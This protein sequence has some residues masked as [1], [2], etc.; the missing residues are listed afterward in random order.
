MSPSHAP[1]DRAT[2]VR[3]LEHDLDAAA[4]GG[5]VLRIVRALPG[6]G[7]TTVLDRLSSAFA[8]RSPQGL[9]LRATGVA[10]ESGRQNGILGQ[11]LHDPSSASLLDPFDAAAA[12]VVT[13]PSETTSLVLIDDAHF[14]DAASL[15]ALAT[16]VRHHPER[17]FVIVLSA[18]TDEAQDGD[19]GPLAGLGASTITLGPM[20]SSEVGRAA[21]AAG[22]PLSAPQAEHLTRHSGGIPRHVSWLL[23]AVPADAWVGNAPVLPAPPSVLLETRHAMAAV[24]SPARAVVEAVAVLF[25]PVAIATAGSVAGVE[26]VLAAVAE[27]ERHGLLLVRDRT[28]TVALALPDPLIRAAVRADM[29]PTRR[30][31]LHRAA[32]DVVDDP[33]EA[34][35]HAA[36]ATTGPDEGL[37][38]RLATLA[39][40]RASD[41]AWA[42]AAHLY[43]LATRLTP[44]RQA[45]ERRLLQAVDAMVGAGDIPATTDYVAEIESFSET[46]TRNAVLGYL[47][48]LRGRA[49]EAQTRLDRAWQLSSSRSPDLAAMIAQRHV[50]HHLAQCEGE[51]LVL[52]ADRAVELVGRD[53]PTAVEAQA[54]RGLGLGGAGHTTEALQSYSRLQARSS[55][56]AVGQRVRMGAGWLHLA[57]DDIDDARS[58]L[59][60]AVPTDFL[61]G[62]QRISLWARCW[63]ARTHFV[64]GE[65]D[66]ALAVAGEGL[67][68]AE[69]TG[70]TLLVPLLRWT[71]TQIH[72]LRGDWDVALASARAGDQGPREYE[73]M[74][75]PACL[76]R[77]ALAE[78]RADYA[79]VLEALAPL[80]RSGAPTDVAEPGFWPWPDVYANALV[81]QGRHDEADAFLEEH[82]LRALTRGHR[83][84]RARLAYARG[85]LF[86]AQ[87][88]LVAARRSFQAGLVHLDSLALPYDRARINFAY[89]QTLRR[90]GKR[91]EADSV[92]TAALDGY[93]ALGASTYVLRC[94]REL[95]AGGV[96]GPQGEHREE[97]LTPAEQ[98]VAAL[99]AQGRSNR[100]V[101]TELFLSIKTV[102]YH[103]TRIYRKLGI[104][105][106][107]ELAAA[108]DLMNQEQD[109]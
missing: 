51:Q 103:L 48:I 60:S 82:E 80:V 72:A 97:A 33:A 74:R 12:F 36:I 15:R 9:L 11:L 10:W 42:S 81:L 14:A 1:V 76:G 106:R 7:R 52:W 46:A 30:A 26:D 5:P 70:M 16:A 49:S 88:D 59:A 38:A 13:L 96:G 41:G 86:G 84:A 8:E 31:E 21:A 22:I 65:W 108:P 63:L 2:A 92:I 6:L 98:S 53:D 45:R 90:A 58:E 93:V 85:R 44:S 99:V 43:L 101:A 32:A 73:V 34:L 89:G 47:A 75:V 28:S 83:S 61:G 23:G 4:Q 77:A 37:A 102:Q 66:Q 17:A 54:I 104:R 68:Q 105:S 39:R 24:T 35:E 19:G 95:R 50:L 27:A 20:T 3:A 57:T 78:A 56:G 67:L 40:R 79:G 25:D 71:E 18:S 107:T 55:H 64:T 29:G 87:G 94:E 109:R 62:S 100:E 91:R 69:R